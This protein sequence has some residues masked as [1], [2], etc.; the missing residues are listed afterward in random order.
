[1][2]DAQTRLYLATLN[3]LSGEDTPERRSLLIGSLLESF[4]VEDLAGLLPESQDQI[5]ELKRIAEIDLD[6]LG[7]RPPA[8]VA[9]APQVILEFFLD[10]D[11]A[12]QVNLAL[13]VIAHRHPEMGGRSDA[14]VHL[15]RSHLSAN[16]ASPVISPA[17][18]GKAGADS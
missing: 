15:A 12:K 14:L 13:D 9:G 16:G 18:E 8:E 5:A 3:R 7:P 4:E 17:G 10:R 11:G 1:V 6:E 2:D